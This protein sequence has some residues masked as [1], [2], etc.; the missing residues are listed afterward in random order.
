MKNL[1]LALASAFVTA[2]AF[3][4]PYVNV[5]SNSSLLGTDYNS[6]V[7][8]L[9]VG[10]EGGNDSFDYYIQGGPAVVAYDGEDSDTR[11]S[12][13]VGANIAATEKLGFYGEVAVLTAEEDTDDDN[14]WATKIGA[15]YSF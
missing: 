9:H 5:E 4:G 7:T 2:P 15:K 14:S 8:D 12:G 1:A 6:T 13:K 3:A 11:L 10:W